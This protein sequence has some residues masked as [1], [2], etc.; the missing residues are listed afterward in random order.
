MCNSTQAL[1][2][3]ST[4]RIS[5][6]FHICIPQENLG[7]MLKLNTDIVMLGVAVK[8][9]LGTGTLYS[10]CVWVVNDRGKKL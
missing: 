5:F 8:A 2:A 10:E 7:C 1:L 3:N 9:E 4:S 6:S